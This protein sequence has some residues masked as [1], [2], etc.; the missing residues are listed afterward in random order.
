[1]IAALREQG[2]T[3]FALTGYCYGGSYCDRDVALFQAHE[4]H[5]G[6]MLFDLAF[7]NEIQVGAT[8]HPSLLQIE[9]L[10]VRRSLL[11]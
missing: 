10:E 8:S 2:V 5:S 9:D 4:C 7:A 11:E 1:M 6:R 3:R